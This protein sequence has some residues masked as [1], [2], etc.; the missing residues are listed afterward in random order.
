MG[1]SAE[2]M[3]FVISQLQSEGWVLDD[4]LIVAPS[5]GIWFSEG[6]FEGWTPREMH[7]I[8]G[9]RGRRVER[10]RRSGWEQFSEEHF[11]LCRAIE[12]M[13]EVGLRTE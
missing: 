1:F 6:H 3:D 8:I 11:Q 2:Q 10:E 5:D 9:D 12:K 13:W 4:D 7:E